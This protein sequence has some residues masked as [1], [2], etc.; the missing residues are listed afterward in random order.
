MNEEVTQEDLDEIKAL[1]SELD[2][3]VRTLKRL[4]SEDEEKADKEDE[5]ADS[6]LDEL[7]DV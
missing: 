3:S 4:V 2:Q 6:V 5:D 1:T 7:N